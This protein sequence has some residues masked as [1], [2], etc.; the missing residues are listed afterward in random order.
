[1]V[2][3]AASLRAL[4]E[5]DTDADLSGLTPQEQLI[6]I[7]RRC[8]SLVG[9]LYRLVTDDLLPALAGAGIRILRFGEL[10]DAR[11]G[12][13]RQ[14]FRDAILP[15]LTPLA[16]DV[17]RP[18]P[19]L[20]SLSLNLAVLL[21]P[22][23]GDGTHRLAIVQVPPGLTRVVEVATADGYACVLL[24]DLIRAHLGLLFP[25]QGIVESAIIRISRDAELEL[26]DEGGRTHLEVVE[27]EVRRRRQS[28]V[29][30]LEAEA[31]A[32]E[33]LL[34]LL[35]Q[36]L[37]ITPD[38]VMTVPGPLDL[39]VLLHLT[40]LPGLEHLHD[41]PLQPAAAVSD[42][43]LAD[44][45]AVLDRRDIL[46]HHPYDGYEPVVAFLNQAADDPDVLAIKQTL[47]RTS[48]GSPILAALQ[49]AAPKA[50]SR[51]PCWWS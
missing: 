24:E 49:R 42:D 22:A 21:A 12:T 13:L 5:G 17:S 35:R 45:S 48:I 46:L 20:S 28:D 34:G 6:A 38:E 15:V 7:R 14:F 9:E 37:E 43:E 33:H 36:Q 31:T 26:D 10:G 1:M 18:F 19:L 3:V 50:T 32:S 11:S 51:S 25:G 41:P 30:R 16:I 2:R 40:E 47:Y 23:K 29:V 27:R 44:L 8:Q 39:R 4:E